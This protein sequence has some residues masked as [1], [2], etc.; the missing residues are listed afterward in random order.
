M[1]AGQINRMKSLFVVLGGFCF[2]TSGTIQAFA[3]DGATPFVV[4]AL[5]M[6]VGGLALLVWCLMTHKFQSMQKISLGHLFLSALSLVGFQLSFFGGVL[7]V[8]VAVGTVVAIGFSPIAASI[9][10]IFVLKEF[11]QKMWY[12]STAIALIGLYLL[13]M[14][15]SNEI[16]LTNMLLPLAAGLSYGCYFI[17]SKP[18]SVNNSPELIMMFVCLCSSIILLPVYFYYP[19]QWIFTGKG[20]LTALGLGVITTAMAFSFVLIGLKYTNASN[21]VTLALSEPLVASFLGIFV[22]DE[23]VTISMAAGI[24]CI[25]IGVVLIGFTQK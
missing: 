8:G 13:N 2:G 4:G 9:L 24:V 21:A 1:N 3:P 15:F 20:I 5:R 11:P 22:L 10:A 19:V 18:L 16:K 14:D 25:L 6:T 7:K 12:I 23:R 17:F